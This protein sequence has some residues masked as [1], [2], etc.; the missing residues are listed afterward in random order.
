MF[1]IRLHLYTYDAFVFFKLKPQ[2]KK[3]V[4]VTVLYKLT[5]LNFAPSWIVGGFVHRY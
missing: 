1:D 4:T 5:L 3:L 2:K